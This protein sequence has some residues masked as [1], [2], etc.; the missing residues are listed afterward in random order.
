MSG[1]DLVEQQEISHSRKEF[2]G[3]NQ[4]QVLGFVVERVE[5]GLVHSFTQGDTFTKSKVNWDKG[6]N[7]EQ[8]EK[9]AKVSDE[10]SEAV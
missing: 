5:G 4:C 3:D 8:V 9:V 7:W 1:S 10:G 2:R 6:N